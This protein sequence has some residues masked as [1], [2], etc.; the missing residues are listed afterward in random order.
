MAIMTLSCTYLVIKLH[1]KIENWLYLKNIPMNQFW[2]CDKLIQQN[3]SHM[4]EAK[5][6]GPYFNNLIVHLG[7]L[8]TDMLWWLHVFWKLDRTFSIKGSQFLQFSHHWQTE[9]CFILTSQ[10][11]LNVVSS[12]RPLVEI[13]R[14]PFSWN[15]RKPMGSITWHRLHDLSHT[16]TNTQYYQPA[17]VTIIIDIT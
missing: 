8:W 15:Y 14:S 5:M 1:G 6:D 9:H 17:L 16:H 11:F 7:T 2:F 4:Y 12:M 10:Y 13:P 3:N